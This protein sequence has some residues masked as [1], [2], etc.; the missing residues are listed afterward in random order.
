MRGR[1]VQ[2]R[3]R[4]LVR[5]LL[6]P[7]LARLGACLAGI[8]QLDQEHQRAVVGDD[9]LAH[10]PAAEE[11]RPHPRLARAQGQVVGVLAIALGHDLVA[12]RAEL[13]IPLPPAPH[14][15]LVDTQPRRRLAMAAAAAQQPEIAD[16]LA[17]AALWPRLPR[18]RPFDRAALIAKSHDRPPV[19]RPSR[20]DSPE[21]IIGKDRIGV[22]SRS[23]ATAPSR[24]CA[25]RSSCTGRAGGG[26]R[27]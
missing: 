18:R 5:A 3:E 17:P 14:R 27:S 22:K 6:A 25:R 26:R 19:L 11:D 1:R 20:P 8:L 21:G 10:L 15:A 12:A 16:P 24:P 9:L 13:G 7:L 2:F 4:Q 23:Q